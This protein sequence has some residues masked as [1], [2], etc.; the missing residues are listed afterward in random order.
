MNTSLA[1][2]TFTFVTITIPTSTNTTPTHHTTNFQIKTTSIN[3]TPPKTNQLTN[4]PTNYNHTKQFNKPQKFTFKKPYKNLQN[5]K[6]F[7][8]NNP[9]INY[10]NN[11]H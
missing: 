3:Y 10:N 6:H 7:N 11:K 1:T 5:S 4:N 8:S 9:Y 2:T